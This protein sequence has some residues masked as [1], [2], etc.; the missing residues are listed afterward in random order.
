M[1]LRF[2]FLKHYYRGPLDF[3]TEDLQA[4]EKTYKRL[5]TFFADVDIDNILDINLVQY[6][7]I[8]VQ[9][10]ECLSDDFNTSGMFGVL[11][12]HLVDLQENI[13]SKELVKYFII[14]VLGLT[15][16]PMKE[17]VI[18]RTTEIEELFTLREKA[19]IEK[20][21]ALADSLRDQLKLLGFEV[22]DKKL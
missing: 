10:V 19:R 13:Y 3:S 20:N 4:A 1:V 21:W 14:Q 15:L 8:V 12:E 17:K 9:M 6:N 18:E 16:E 11:F 22:Q 7:P 5:V 2:Y